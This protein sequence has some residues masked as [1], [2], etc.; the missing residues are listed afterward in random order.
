MSI[1]HLA[2]TLAVPLI[3]AAGTAAA[4]PIGYALGNGGTQLLSFDVT[5]PGSVNVVS[6]GGDGTRLDAIDFRPATGDLYGYDDDSDL[7]FVVDPVTGAL[8]NASGTVTATDTRNLDIDWNPTIDRMRTV[9]ESDQNIVYNPNTGGASDA[10]T[11]ALF[12]GVGDANDGTDPNV[13]A[14]AYSNSFAGAV[15]TTQYVLDHELDILATLAN[16]AGTLTTIG[17]LGVDFDAAAGLD[18]FSS[19]GNTAY[20]L[21]NVAGTPGL[22]TIDLTTGAATS[23]GGFPVGQFND[24]SGLAVTAVPEPAT[25]G[26]LAAG[27]LGLFL[28]RRRRSA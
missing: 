16:N 17:S 26:L 6:L 24:I 11:T 5:A 27:G 8:S 1:R 25:V 3:F 28:F 2:G 14:N 12:Y 20:A 10:T 13:T 19:G 7:Y 4:G 21:L 23:I 18:I 22:Y 15:T 9:T